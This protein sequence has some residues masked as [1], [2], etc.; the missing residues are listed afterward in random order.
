MLYGMRW[1]RP[2]NFVVPVID[3]NR[4]AADAIA[5]VDIPP[6]VSNHIA[7]I[8]IDG[9]VFACIQQESGFWLSTVALIPV[10]MTTDIDSFNG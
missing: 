1:S 10:I 8:E 7:L 9:E 3:K 6:T 4:L 2:Q 5:C